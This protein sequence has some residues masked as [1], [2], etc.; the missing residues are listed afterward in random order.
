MVYHDC[1]PEVHYLHFLKMTR[2][3]NHQMMAYLKN[4]SARH[5]LVV[6]LHQKGGE[7]GEDT[8]DNQ[9][10]LQWRKMHG[11]EVTLEVEKNSQSPLTADLQTGQR[12]E[13]LHHHRLR[14]VSGLSTQHQQMSL[15]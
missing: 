11:S 9:P 12:L 7:E 6:H 4:C 10:H 15:I 3:S 2:I 14:N 13:P 8:T 1:L 5:Q